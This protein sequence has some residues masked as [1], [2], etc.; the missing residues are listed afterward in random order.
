LIYALTEH[1]YDVDG[2][3]VV[4]IIRYIG[5]YFWPYVCR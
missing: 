2:E 5:V 1:G 3:Y 4:T